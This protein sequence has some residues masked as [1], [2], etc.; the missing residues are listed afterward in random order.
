MDRLGFDK[1]WIDLIMV[2]LSSV[3][4]S[5]LI[6]GE[7]RGLVTPS[8][9]LRQGDPLSP[10]LFILCAE[11]LSALISQFVSSGHLHGLKVCDGAPTISHL[12]FAMIASSMLKQLL[13]I[14]SL[15]NIFW[16]PMNVRLVNKLTSRRAMLCLLFSGN[17]LPDLRIPWL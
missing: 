4:Y 9:G 17:V 15:L 8:R 7:P 11:G 2:C 13:K 5:F 16:R 3:R 12:L 14:V 10:Y 1:E 6:K